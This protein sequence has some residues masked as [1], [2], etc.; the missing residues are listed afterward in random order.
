MAYPVRPAREGTM[1]RLNGSEIPPLAEGEK[2]QIC[3]VDEWAYLKTKEVMDGKKPRTKGGR[4]IRLIKAG[5]AA[6][7][8]A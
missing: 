1:G 8:V 3:T 5:R 6:T 7:M 4:P 2:D